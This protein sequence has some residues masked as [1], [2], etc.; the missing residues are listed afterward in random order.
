MYVICG[1]MYICM[2]A[3][4]W[5]SQMKFQFNHLAT[6]KIHAHTHTHTHTHTYTHTYFLSSWFSAVA[7]F[8]LPSPSCNL[9]SFTPGPFSLTVSALAKLSSLYALSLRS[10]YTE[11]E[12]FSSPS[13][14][15][16]S[17]LMLSFSSMGV[18]LSTGGGGRR[19]ARAV[20]PLLLLLVLSLFCF[21][22]T[23]LVLGMYP[24][25]ATLTRLFLL[26]ILTPLL[27]TEFA[28][29]VSALLD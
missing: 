10:P 20:L 14:L 15:P 27:C 28:F 2:H 6:Y 3:C 21:S 29:S 13:V 11:P 16:E 17:V 8:F 12:C 7:L 26:G 23:P 19:D 25:G 22:C 24:R 1:C 5:D 4:T 9:S 18:S